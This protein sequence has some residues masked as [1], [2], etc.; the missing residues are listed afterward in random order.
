[1]V[2]LSVN[3]GPSVFGGELA[4][5]IRQKQTDAMHSKGMRRIIQEALLWQSAEGPHDALVSIET[6]VPGLSC[7]ITCV[8]LRLAVFKQYRSVTDTDRQTDGQTHDDGMYR[9]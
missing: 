5:G 7:G 3:F 8:I 1:M 4:A 9:A 2:F 6:R